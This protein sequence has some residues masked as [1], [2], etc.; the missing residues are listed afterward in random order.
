MSGHP[1]PPDCRFGPLSVTD[2]VRY[3]GASGDFNPLHHDPAYAAAA[4]LPTV[5]A[6][7]MLS[8]G[9]LGSFLTQWF[10]PGR[11]RRYKARFRE[12]VFPGDTLTPEGRV[13]GE[14]RGEDGG[15]LLDLE[16]ALRRQDGTAVVT[17]EATVGA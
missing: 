2:L 8:A 1:P 14:R 12:R 17:A 13:T 4:G 6:H 10:G 9:F 5:M 15:R 11:V 7:G 3:A 16:L